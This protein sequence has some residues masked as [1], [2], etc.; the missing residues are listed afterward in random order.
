MQREYYLG[1]ASRTGF[2]TS[3][4]DENSQH[5]GILL[6]GGPGTGKSTLMK[7]IA[8][9]FQNE[10]V[11]VYHC[12][13]DPHSLDAVV[14]EQRGVYI[15]D[16]T[17]P[18]TADTP[19][20]YITGEICNLA[21]E[22]DRH[23]LRESAAEAKALYAENQAMHTHVR[24]TLGGLAAMQAL[25][26]ETAAAALDGEK[27]AGYAQRF[28]KRLLPKSAGGRG[29]LLR[30]QMSA[31]T[32]DGRQTFIPAHSTRLLL[33][34][35]YLSAAESLLT[36]FAESAVSAGLRTEVTADL[37]QNTQPLCCV[38]L[39]ELSL[40]V[41]A[42]QKLPEGVSE[43]ASVISLRRF[44]DA[45]ALRPQRSLLK[46]CVE[47]AAALEAEAV[48]VLHSALV[49]HDALEEAFIQALDPERLD[50]LAQ[51]LTAR[52]KTEF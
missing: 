14:L 2:Q 15:A 37:T 20:P 47:T 45:A 40:F 7:K 11:S 29:V 33:S 46:F 19:L 22:L 27:L 38:Y 9:A 4:W 48:S 32:P 17:A 3:F 1:G 36:V 42:E 28:C 52:L 23:L 39:P 24:K 41:S 49:C 50:T 26:A 21:E 31:L 10:T 34:D 8:A 25:R 30:R 18:H 43:N 51:T 12:A 16:A 13:S 5:Y 35:P 6:K 44:Y